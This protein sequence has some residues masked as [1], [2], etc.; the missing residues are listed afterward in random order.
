MCLLLVFKTKVIPHLKF[1]SPE[2]SKVA[3]SSNH[4]YKYVSR[5][6]I[7]DIYYGKKWG[8]C[9]LLGYSS[10]VIPNL[11]FRRAEFL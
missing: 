7:C 2:L 4:A 3:H 1:S 8:I 11:K 10:K 5:G 6:E 9:L